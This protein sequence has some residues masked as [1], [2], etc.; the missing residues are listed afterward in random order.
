VDL[1]NQIWGI[2]RIFGLALPPGGSGGRRFEA[3]V[4]ERAPMRPG[5]IRTPADQLG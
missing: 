1:A 5:L 3:A 4:R 2:L